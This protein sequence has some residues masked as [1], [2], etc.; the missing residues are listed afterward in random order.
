MPGQKGAVDAPPLAVQIRR[1]VPERLRR[2][3]E[4]V[5]QEDA[6][7]SIRAKIDRRRACDYSVSARR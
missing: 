2:V 5:Q 6:M 1:E 3:A 4:P 7:A